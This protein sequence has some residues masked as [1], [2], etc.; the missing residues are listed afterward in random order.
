MLIPTIVIRNEPLG[1]SIA[2]NELLKLCPMLE[3]SEDLNNV[4]KWL[5]TDMNDYVDWIHGC[6]QE[7][8]MEDK[9][10][11]R[12]GVVIGSIIDDELTFH[13]GVPL[14]K[15]VAKDFE[16]FI[17]MFVRKWWKKYQT[18]V[19]IVFEMPKQ[20]LEVGQPL[21]LPSFTKS[22]IDAMI[23]GIRG[24]FM[25]Y[26]EVCATIP[27]AQNLLQTHLKNSGK[28]EWS[29]ADKINLQTRLLRLAK[30]MSY[31]HGVLIFIKPNKANRSSLNEFRN[32]DAAK[33]M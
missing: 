17:V 19:K 5:V 7:C 31:T 24:K 12:D 23:K 6:Y 13:L 22:E 33:T 8:P 18:R 3:G 30:E 15:G 26:G 4:L 21:E 25:Q 11:I 10:I 28:K 16:E 2:K 29:V 27:L 1:A 9:D 14:Y 32:D 20:A